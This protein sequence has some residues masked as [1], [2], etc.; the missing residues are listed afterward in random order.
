MNEW[1]KI[2]ACVLCSGQLEQLNK[3]S[4]TMTDTKPTVRNLRGLHAI[5]LHLEYKADGPQTSMVP[6]LIKPL[7]SRSVKG[8]GQ[9]SQPLQTNTEQHMSKGGRI[10]MRMRIIMKWRLPNVKEKK[11]NEVA[12]TSCQICMTGDIDWHI[13]ILAK[14][15][16]RGLDALYQIVPGKIK[17]WY[18]LTSASSCMNVWF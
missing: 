13:H 5:L 18:G 16:C 12:Q 2:V 17:W 14:V 1:E 15:E 4:T 7:L 9:W 8:G 6:Q 10:S 3:C 11:E